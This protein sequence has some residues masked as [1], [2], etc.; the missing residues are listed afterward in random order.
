MRRHNAR[1][2]GNKEEQDT[3]SP[4]LMELHVS[5]IVQFIES[6]VHLGLLSFV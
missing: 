2:W 5:V 6:I 3:C 4:V 1:C